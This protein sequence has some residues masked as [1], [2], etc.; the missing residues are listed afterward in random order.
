MTAEIGEGVSEVVVVEPTTPPHRTIAVLLPNTQTS[1]SVFGGRCRLM[2]FVGY[3]SAGTGVGVRLYNGGSA[4]GQEVFVTGL[5]AGT[6]PAVWFGD[7]GIDCDGG[8][9]WTGNLTASCE[10]VVYVRYRLAG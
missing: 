3:N 5:P 9:F 2:G 10:V 1:G 7:E 4:Q 8:I 6:C